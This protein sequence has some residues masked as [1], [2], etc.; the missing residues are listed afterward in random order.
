MDQ[1]ERDEALERAIEGAGGTAE[2]ARKIAEQT[3]EKISSQAISQWR[4]APP[5]RVLQIE[6]ACESKVT[7]HE[8]RS[9]LYPEEQRA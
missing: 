2:L 1:H 5:N 7:R 9:D 4:R 8:L 3:G 6:R